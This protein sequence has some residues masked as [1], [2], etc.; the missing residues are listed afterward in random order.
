M[1]KETKSKIRELAVYVLVGLLATV[2][3]YGVRLALI[4]GGA[5]IFSFD[6]SSE[7]AAMAAKVSVLRTVATTVGSFAAIV[8]TFYPNKIWVFRNYD[9]TNVKKQ[10]LSFAGSRVLTFLLELGFA[11]VLPLMLN[12]FGYKTFRFV[13]D[14][15]ADM[16]SSLISI[17]VITVLNY[18]I[19]KFLVFRKKNNNI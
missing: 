10:F 17:V 11:V 1:N 6:L 5:A 7:E 9:K 8:A 18:V 3:S 14:I 13:I 12:A 15:D 19:S 2:I 16:M 4:Y